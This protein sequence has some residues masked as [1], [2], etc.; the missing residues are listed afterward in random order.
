MIEVTG[1]V[2]KYRA[3]TIRL[4]DLKSDHEV[5]YLQG[6]NG[7]GKTTLLK[8]IAGI[9]PYQ[10]TIEVM[11]PALYVDASMPVPLKTLKSLKTLLTREAKTLFE[12]WFNLE[13]EALRT[14]ECSLGMLQK[15]RLCLALSY[16]VMTLLLDEPLRGLDTKA[17]IEWIKT[18]N[19]TSKRVVITSHEIFDCP[20]SW[21]IIDPF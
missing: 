8:A 3:K 1:F 7:S 21:A 9:I 17:K 16:P 20:A 12:T 18:L 6:V 13:D 5:I 10:G 15:I 14:D 2:K 4:D 19:E 11:R